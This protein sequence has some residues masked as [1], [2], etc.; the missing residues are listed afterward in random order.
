M[1]HLGDAESVAAH[2]KGIAEFVPCLVVKIA[3][4]PVI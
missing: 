4:V 1:T 2:S 3:N